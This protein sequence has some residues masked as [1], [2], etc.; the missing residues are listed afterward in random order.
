MFTE[1]P[2]HIILHERRGRW[3][4]KTGGKYWYKHMYVHRVLEFPETHGFEDVQ[5]LREVTKSK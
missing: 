2:A 1:I 4:S 3:S 5:Q